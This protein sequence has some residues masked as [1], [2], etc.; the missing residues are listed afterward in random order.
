MLRVE[1]SYAIVVCDGEVTENKS[2]YDKNTSFWS[3]W[4][5]R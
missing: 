4:A 5:F 2:S 3:M 1:K